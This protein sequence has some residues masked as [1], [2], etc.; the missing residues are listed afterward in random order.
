MNYNLK[1]ESGVNDRETPSTAKFMDSL[2]E[3]KRMAVDL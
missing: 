1:L 2:T 3:L